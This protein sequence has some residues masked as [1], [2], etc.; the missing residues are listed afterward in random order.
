MSTYT[1]LLRIREV[2]RILALGLMVRIPLFGAFVVLV[3]HVVDHLGRSYGMAGFLDMCSAAA[4]AISGPWRGRLLDRMGLRRVLGPALGL[5]AA[6][7][8]VAPW[9]NYWLLLGLVVLAGLFTPPVFTIVRQVII[10]AVPDDKRTAALSLDG[11]F[12]EL[13]FMAGPVLG[14]LLAT[15]LDTPVAL[16]IFQGLAVVGGL[17]IWIDNPRLTRES[18]AAHEGPD[19]QV[20]WLTPWVVAILA[21]TLTVSIVLTGEDL[22]TVAALRHMEHA[23]SIGWVLALWG[24]SSAI[25]G[26][27]YGTLKA[28]PPSYVLMALLVVTTVPIAFAEDRWLFALLLFLSGFFCSPTITATA[29]DLSRAVPPSRLGE[30]MGMYAS[31]LTTGGAIGAPIVGFAIDHYGWPSAFLVVGAIGTLVTVAGVLAQ[32]R[33]RRNV[34]RRGANSEQLV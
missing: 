5:Y 10:A 4:I 21:I 1:D 6:C 32:Q 8:I 24:L 15:E 31:A 23:S 26:I 29:D 2:R 7:W 18:D 28:H 19:P 30:A 16:A 9:V 3:L 13:S 27:V 11:V 33:R 14:V 22:G 12:V 20:P 25:G 34:V 17:V